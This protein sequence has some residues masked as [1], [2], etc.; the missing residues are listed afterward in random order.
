MRFL[1]AAWKKP[2]SLRRLFHNGCA[3]GDKKEN[4]ND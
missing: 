3:I 1:G 4:L 2:L